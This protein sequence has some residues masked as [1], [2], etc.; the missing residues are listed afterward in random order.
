MKAEKE[1][2]ADFIMNNKLTTIDIDDLKQTGLLISATLVR[3]VLFIP[4]NGYAMLIKANYDLECKKTFAEYAI[5]SGN[6]ETPKYNR[7]HDYEKTYSLQFIES[8]VYESRADA[9]GSAKAMIDNIDDDWYN[10][11]WDA[12]DGDPL[13]SLT[14]K[15]AIKIMSDAAINGLIIPKGTTPESVIEQF[16][17]IKGEE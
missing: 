17:D 7:S 4:H 14:K 8:I 10:F 6:G 11:L 12:T 13:G 9:I 5:Y 16:N 2:I 1:R 3:D 15:D